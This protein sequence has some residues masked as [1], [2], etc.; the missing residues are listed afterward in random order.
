MK[1]DNS[2]NKTPSKRVNT[3]IFYSVIAGVAVGCGIGAGFG[4]HN[5]L[6]VDVVD[7]SAVA[8][9][10]LYDDNTHILDDFKKANAPYSETLTP[11]KMIS[12]SL[13]QFSNA[14]TAFSQGIGQSS[15]T[16]FPITQDIRST[17]IKTADGCF[18][19]SL[20]NSSFVHL[21]DRMYQKGDNTSIY[22][23]S[24]GSDVE[25]GVY[26]ETATSVMTNEEYATSMG[27]RVDCPCVYIVSDKTV[28]KDETTLSGKKVTG[29]IQNTDGTYTVDVELNPEYACY[30]YKTQMKTISDLK[31]RPKFNYCHLTFEMDQNLNLLSMTSYEEYSATTSGGASSTCDGVLRT[32]YET[33]GEYSIP[34][35]NVAVPYRESM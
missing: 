26:P 10:A 12:I 31:Y 22:K 6:S 20:S 13:E 14:D 35:G 25:H 34:E 2:K 19:E 30:N 18:E 7:D 1:K 24:I 17:F 23:G 16:V 3:I 4:L 32:V 29:A 33:G 9:N 21:A 5:L 27:R 28:M 15:P 8:A 11:R